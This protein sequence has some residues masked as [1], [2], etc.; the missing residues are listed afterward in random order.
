VDTEAIRPEDVALAT[1]WSN[2]YNFDCIIS[3]DGD[4]DRPLISDEKGRWL[5]G[6]VAG[7]LCA[8]Y[9]AADAVITPVNCNSA[10]ELSGAFLTIQQEPRSAR[11][12]L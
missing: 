4:G 5:R 11:L 7:I 2:E 10:L 6:D 3:T 1:Q 8:Q 9:L 12:L